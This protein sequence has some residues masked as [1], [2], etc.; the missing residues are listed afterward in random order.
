M[1]FAKKALDFATEA[2]KGQNDKGGKPYIKHPIYVANHV[3]GDTAKAVAYLHDV[4]E[5]TKYT[6]EDLRRA[7]FSHEIVEAVDI[8]TKKDGMSYEKYIEKVAENSIATMV[9]VADLQHNS[10]L[11]RI[12]NPTEKDYGRCRTY[13]KMI[14]R[15][16]S[17][18]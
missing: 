4:V 8:L 2:H 7:G 10:Q 9:K 5:D 15:L 12:E 11:D 18:L 1:K 14:E 13:E 16:K 6:L 17:K 3:D